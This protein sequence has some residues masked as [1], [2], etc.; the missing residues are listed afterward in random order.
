M[1][2]ASATDRSKSPQGAWPERHRCR[3]RTR[4]R[5]APVGGTGNRTGGQAGPR[6][7]AARRGRDHCPLSRVLGRFSGRAA[8]KSTEL[9]TLYP[10]STCCRHKDGEEEP[11]MALELS[12]QLHDALA[13]Y[14][15]LEQA[16]GIGGTAIGPRAQAR[17][18]PGAPQFAEQLGLLGLLIAQDR[19]LAETP[20]MQQDMSRL[21]TTFRFALGQH[22][23]E[24]AGG[25]DRRRSQGLCP[26]GVGSLHEVRPVLG[27]VPGK[28]QFPPRHPCSAR[29]PRLARR[30]ALRPQLRRFDL[31]RSRG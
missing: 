12:S 31:I 7:H 20:D 16:V 26:V 8:V 30:S 13:R 3:A 21:F 18:C 24:L 22:R 27:L 4:N 11:N 1:S 10:S 2:A 17:S 29:P 9:L 28:P 25:P 15:E 14:A 19:M 23:G 5:R 6:R